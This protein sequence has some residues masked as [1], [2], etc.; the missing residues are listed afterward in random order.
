MFF[1]ILRA[2]FVY[3]FWSFPATSS[4]LILLGSFLF[5]L[6]RKPSHWLTAL[7]STATPEPVSIFEFIVTLLNSSDSWLAPLMP[8]HKS[9][10][11]FHVALSRFSVLREFKQICIPH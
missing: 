10:I 5:A 9:A 8:E 11:I 3:V 4:D 1:M 6:L 2:I 7:F